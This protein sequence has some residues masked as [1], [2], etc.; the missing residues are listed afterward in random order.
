MRKDKETGQIIYDIEISNEHREALAWANWEWMRSLGGVVE[1]LD[2]YREKMNSME[3]RISM[4]EHPRVRALYIQAR[5]FDPREERN[6]P[7]P[8]WL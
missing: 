2:F 6:A 8:R 4:L 5:G 7:R 3:A 1:P